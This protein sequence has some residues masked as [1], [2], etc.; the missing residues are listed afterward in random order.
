MGVLVQIYIFRIFKDLWGCWHRYIYLGFFKDLLGV[1]APIYIY[2]GFFKD[3][4]GVLVQIYIH[5]GFFKDLWG[6]LVQI[7][8][9]RVL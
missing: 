2:L 6:V 1:L 5:L 4:W 7:Y 9:F 3:L 8:I